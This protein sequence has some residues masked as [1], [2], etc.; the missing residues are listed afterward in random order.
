MWASIVAKLLGS[1]GFS[2]VDRVLGH[3]EKRADNETER[4]RIGAGREAAANATAS[5]VVKTGMQHK[6]FWIPWLL[7]AVPLSAWFAWG[8][9]D[10]M[11]NGML[12]D[13]AT[14]PPQLKEYADIVW[15]N[16]FYVG[17]GVAGLHLVANAIRGRK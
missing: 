1:V 3:L 7:A 14:L 12:P 16:I 8:V 17:G 2:F 11:L 6:A 10:S 4:Q 15:G 13:V 5:D 9:S